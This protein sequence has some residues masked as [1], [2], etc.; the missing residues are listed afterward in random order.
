[1]SCQGDLCPEWAQLLA[2]T[3]PG[4]RNL[5]SLG[6]AKTL[7]SAGT[8]LTARHLPFPKV[9]AKSQANCPLYP[10]QPKVRGGAGG[11]LPPREISGSEL[12]HPLQSPSCILP[13]NRAPG[14]RQGQDYWLRYMSTGLGPVQLATGQPGS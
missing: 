4:H 12:M 8:T 2:A 10:Y 3:S 6:A 11:C 5:A 9:T 14:V 7:N 1:M 13:D